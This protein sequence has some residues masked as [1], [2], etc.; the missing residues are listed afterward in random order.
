MSLGFIRNRI[1]SPAFLIFVAM[2]LIYPATERKVQTGIWHLWNGDTIR[3]QEYDINVPT[4]WV[5]VTDD[6]KHIGLVDVKRSYWR[7][8]LHPTIVFFKTFPLQGEVKDMTSKF[9]DEY[10]KSI[11]AQVFD[12]R[13]VDLDGEQIDCEASNVLVS[14]LPVPNESIITITCE[15]TTG[16]NIISSGNRQ[17]LDT[18][19]SVVSQIR[20]HTD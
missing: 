8:Q 10:L 4:N 5:A 18:F 19:F 11:N 16:L 17:N 9:H 13:T 20:K 3:F 15:S 2:L 14:Q 7:D 6:P 12:H 1:N